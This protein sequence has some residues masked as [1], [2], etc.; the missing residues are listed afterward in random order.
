MTGS[1]VAR[2]LADGTRRFDVRWRFAGKQFNRT[3]ARYREAERFRADLG[4]KLHDGTWRP[5]RALPMAEVFHLWLEQ[6]VAPRVNEGSLKRSTAKG[7]RT[8]VTEHLVP[9]FG[10]VR[11][12][13]LSLSLVEDWRAGLA[14]KIADGGMSSKTYL[15]LRNVLHAVTTWARHPSRGFM[16]HDPLDGLERLRLPRAKRRPHFEP[17]QIAELFRAAAATPPDE[18]IIEVAALSGLRR[19]ELFALQWSDLD[20]GNGRDGGCLH[21]RRRIFMGTLDSPK[22]D[23]SDRVVDVP[24]RLLDHLA[25]YRLLY[26]P[27]GAGFVFRTPEG[28][29]VDPDR[30]HKRHL[31]PILKRAGLRLRGAGLHSLRHS[32]ISMLAAQPGIDIHYVSRQAGHSGTAITQDIYRHVLAATQLQAMRGLNDAIPFNSH[33]TGRAATA[34]NGRNEEERAGL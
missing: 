22:T 1:I 3:F 5:L 10:K 12:D 18:V 31:V 2:N 23:G 34:S 27:I 13:Q 32:Y 14:Q 33:S 16:A 15:N 30:W 11:S 20:V 24:Q 17:E 29:P 6:S 7:Y 8:A 26:P 21:V 9:A 28:Q 19:S 25:V 4:K